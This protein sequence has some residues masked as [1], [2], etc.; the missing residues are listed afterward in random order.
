[1]KVSKIKKTYKNPSN[2]KIIRIWQFIC[3][4]V[5][6]F[7]LSNFLTSNGWEP[8]NNQ[9]IIIKGAIYTPRE[10]ILK[11]SGIKF[12]KAILEI[13][14]KQLE[15]NLL[16]E[17]PIKAVAIKR[18]IAPL[19]IDIEIL[20][21][22]PIAFALRKGVNGQEKGMVD[23]EG[24][25]IPI[26]ELGEGMD[27]LT[28]IIVDGWTE[29]NKELIAF[30]LTNHKELKVPLKRIIF[31]LNGNISLQTEKFMFVHLGNKSAFLKQQL[32]AVAKLAKSIPN[33]LIN[34]SDAILDLENPLKPK[35]FLPNEP[36]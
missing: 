7:L 9:Q 14:P 25:W 18:N 21:R 17:L 15:S 23:K 26:F 34:G 13:N 6:A 28:N 24:Y 22:E 32:I 8:I 3:F 5:I 27:P 4:S 31:N 36:N 20:E 2:L 30:I 29:E 19:S 16:R 11:A 35:L 10:V 33:E 1:M 12:P